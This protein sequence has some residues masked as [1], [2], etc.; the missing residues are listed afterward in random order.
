MVLYNKY[1]PYNFDLICGQEP[2]KKVLSYQV[3][4]D[5]LSHTYLFTGPAGTGKTTI[6]R[7]LAAMINSSAGMTLCPDIADKFVGAIMKGNSTLDVVELD[8]ASQGGIDEI[9]DIRERA[10]YCPAEMRMKVYIIDECH[11]LTTAAW[12]ALLKILEEPPKHVIFILCTTEANKVPETILTRAMSF[13]FLPITLQDMVG[14]IKKITIQEGLEVSEE[15]LRMISKSSAGSMRQALSSLDKLMALGSKKIEAD[16]VSKLIG[17]PS[18]KLAKEYIASALNGKFLIGHAASSEAIGAGISAQDFLE[19]VANYLH[20]LIFSTIPEYDLSGQ[21]YSLED[22][23][24][25]KDTLNLFIKSLENGMTSSVLIRS[26]RIV[27]M[28]HKLSVYNT[29]PQYQVDVV[30]AELRAE[31][32]KNLK[33]IPVS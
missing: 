17:M 1:R 25:L 7:I 4:E 28:G 32:K 20:G 24:E 19:E 16:E 18:R 14:Y 30:W 33:K 26:C 27:D 3:K 23:N 31:I 22:T 13:R 29:Q 12:Q 9:R 10:A 5:K 15:A 2:I 21:G 6:A 11:Q 8:A